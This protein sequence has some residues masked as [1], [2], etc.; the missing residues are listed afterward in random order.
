M[1]KTKES[2]ESSADRFQTR[3]IIRISSLFA[4]S[5]PLIAVVY[6][7]AG[8]GALVIALVAGLAIVAASLLLTW[9]IESLQYVFSQTFALAI[10]AL[11]QNLPEFS[12]EAVLAWEQNIDFAMVGV[13]GAIRLLLGIGWP[14]VIFTY[15]FSSRK[16]EGKAKTEIRLDKSQSTEVFFLLVVTLYGFILLIRQTLDI[17]DSAILAAI[18][19]SYL[20]VAVKTSPESEVG[21]KPV[22]GPSRKILALAR[23]KKFALIISFLGLGI[24]VVFSAAEPFVHSLLE[25][26]L[27]VGVSQFV[28][29]QWL[30]PFLSEFPEKVSAFYWASSRR[31]APMAVGNLVSSNVNQFSL[32]LATIPII[33]ALSV[34]HPQPIHLTLLQ[35]EELFLTIATAIF[36]VVAL[37]D[38][39]L[40]LRDGV[41]LLA[42][43]L[44]QFLIPPLRTEVAIAFLLIALMELISI[45]KEIKIF[46]E[47]RAVVNTIRLTRKS[48]NSS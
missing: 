40:R 29:F 34:G 12:F 13:T 46:T 15:Y 20:Y 45:R 18:F 2:D 28:F 37:M 39:R 47:F 27:I 9:A 30:A 14:L 1:S 48:A 31:F 41:I 4:A 19:I 10:L 22:H 33:Y 26:A 35:R 44:I 38:L 17:V 8:S 21:E 5:I 42:L 25:V 23:R 7:G 3:D 16:H 43:F 36:G 6:F 32:L 11:I 24:F